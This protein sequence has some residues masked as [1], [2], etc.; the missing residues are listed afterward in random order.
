MTTCVSKISMMVVL[1]LMATP[2]SAHPG[3][4]IEAAGHSHWGAL[5]ALGGAIAIGAWVAKGKKKPEASGEAEAEVED[6][7]D[8]ELQE[9]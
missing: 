5:I 9:A 4:L 2:L 7:A 3:H 1:G 6:G 8:A